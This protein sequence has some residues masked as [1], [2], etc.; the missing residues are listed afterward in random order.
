MRIDLPDAA[1][2]TAVQSIRPDEREK[3]AADDERVGDR[4]AETATRKRKPE[5]AGIANTRTRP[6]RQPVTRRLG[7]EPMVDPSQ[8]DRRRQQA[9]ARVMIRMSILLILWAIK[10]Y[11]SIDVLHAVMINSFIFE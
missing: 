5:P 1:W 2:R 8:Q 7:N 10:E 9:M 3:K 4:C 11:R 6:A